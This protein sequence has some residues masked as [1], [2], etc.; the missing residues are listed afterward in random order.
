M[1]HTES[2]AGFTKLRGACHR[3][4]V[5]VLFSTNEV[6][7]LALGRVLASI[8]GGTLSDDASRRTAEEF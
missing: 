6:V 8:A 7:Y 5:V 3:V 4:N 1:D 2:K